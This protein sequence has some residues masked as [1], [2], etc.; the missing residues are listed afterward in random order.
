MVRST[1][2]DESSE[3]GPASRISS[4]HAASAQS[5]HNET[6][7]ENEMTMLIRR[8]GAVVTGTV[9][10]ASAVAQSAQQ[11]ARN[12]LTGVVTH[13][14]TIAHSSPFPAVRKHWAQGIDPQEQARRMILGTPKVGHV[15]APTVAPTLVE[16]P[17]RNRL[18]GIAAPIRTRRSW[19]DG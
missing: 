6:K 19:R 4:Q 11:Q 2:D 7:G 9:I 16:S 18:S 14:A 1:E 3:V 5:V 8:L 17:F 10:T 15:A 12:L 13:Q